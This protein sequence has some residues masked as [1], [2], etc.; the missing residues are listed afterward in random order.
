MAKWTND[1]RAW[2]LLSMG[3]AIVLTVATV[4]DAIWWTDAL[5]GR[6]LATCVLWLVVSLLAVAVFYD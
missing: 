1:P 3:A 5:S 6:L 2:A 4:F